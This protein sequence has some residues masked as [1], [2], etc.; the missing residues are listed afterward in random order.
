MLRGLGLTM[1][2]WTVG[3]IVLRS[4][5][6]A[7]EQCPA[8]GAAGLEVAA[9]E[10]VGW[11][12]RAV[13]PDGRYLYEW[14]TNTGL[15][16]NDYNEVRHAGVTMSLYQRAAHTDDPQAL[17]IG[18]E[19][20]QWMLDNLERRDGWAALR[21]PAT[22]QL[23]LGASALMSAS[24][25]L[26]RDAT[27]DT[28]YDDLIRE[29]G[30][31]QVSLQRGDGS[32]LNAYDLGTGAPIPDVTSKY[33]TGEAFWALAMTHNRFPGEGWDIPTRMVADYL[34]LRRDAVE[35]FAYPPW[36]DQWASYGFSEMAD[37]GLG[38]HHIEYTRS[39]AARFG[40]LVRSE[41]KRR[42]GEFSASVRG[43]MARAAGM[44]TWAEGLNALWRLAQADPRMA[45]LEDSIASRAT[46]AAGMLAARQVNADAAGEYRDAAI[47]RGA[48]FSDGITR[49]DDQQHALSGIILTLEQLAKDGGDE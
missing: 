15:A 41:M 33:A 38:P 7:P 24:L 48:W 4:T 47:A 49:M 31:F 17:A 13:Q 35:A 6:V 3:A 39:L 26:R 12:G 42:D 8:P 21:N 40:L 25:L 18:D 16:S 28:M 23:K 9:S 36:A 20:L 37:W 19:G 44:G 45:D 32:F 46:C 29:L 14:D 43:P 30:R 27:A 2:A 1:A 22:G 34:A 5:V 10:T 11:I